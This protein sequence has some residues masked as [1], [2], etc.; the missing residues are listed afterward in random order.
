MAEQLVANQLAGVRFSLA[1]P[2]IDDVLYIFLFKLI[3]LNKDLI[4]TVD[5][6]VSNVYKG[7]IKNLS[8]RT[9]IIK[10]C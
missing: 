7:H 4:K 10:M 5:N 9:V 3:K 2:R 6:C 1:A 8:F